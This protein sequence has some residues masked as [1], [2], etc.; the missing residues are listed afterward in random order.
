MRPRNIHNAPIPPQNIISAPRQPRNI[1]NA[2]IPPQNIISAP[3]PPQNIISAPRQPR[4]IHNAPIPPQLLDN[5]LY[6]DE[7]NVLHSALTPNCKFSIIDYV[8]RHPISENNKTYIYKNLAHGGFN[9]AISLKEIRIIENENENKYIENSHVI[10]RAMTD[11]TNVFGEYANSDNYYDRLFNLINQPDS[12]FLVPIEHILK[13]KKPVNARDDINYD[14]VKSLETEW[15]NDLNSTPANYILE[16]NHQRI[17]YTYINNTIKIYYTGRTN[18]TSF[19]QDFIKCCYWVMPY[20]YPFQDDGPITLEKVIQ[21]KNCLIKINRALFNSDFSGHDHKYE[22]FMYTD[23]ECTNLVCTDIDVHLKMNT[24]FE[25]NNTIMDQL[26]SDTAIKLLNNVNI[27]R[28]AAI[29][30]LFTNNHYNDIES[31]GMSHKS[32]T[33]VKLER[34]NQIVATSDDDNKVFYYSDIINTIS[35]LISKLIIISSYSSMLS[36]ENMEDNFG[37]IKININV[38]NDISYYIDNNCINAN[39]IEGFLNNGHMF[40]NIVDNNNTLERLISILSYGISINYNLD[41]II[42]NKILYIKYV[43]M[44]ISNV[45][46]LSS[47]LQFT[48]TENNKTK[49]IT[50]RITILDI[51]N[52]SDT[53]VIVSNDFRTV[54]DQNTINSNFQENHCEN[55]MIFM[56]FLLYKCA[57]NNRQPPPTKEIS[58]VTFILSILTTASTMNNSRDFYNYINDLYVGNVYNINDV[59]NE[60]ERKV[61]IFKYKLIYT[62]LI[63]LLDFKVS[64]DLYK[65]ILNAMNMF[66]MIHTD[67]IFQN[68]NNNMPFRSS[69]Y[70]NKNFGKSLFSMFYNNNF[71]TPENDTELLKF[72]SVFSYSMFL[73][74]ST[75]INI[76]NY[77]INS[78]VQTKLFEENSILKIDQFYLIIFI[79]FDAGMRLHYRARNNTYSFKKFY[80]RLTQLNNLIESGNEIR[81]DMLFLKNY[82]EDVIQNNINVILGYIGEN[83][84]YIETY[85]TNHRSKIGTTSFGY[86]SREHDFNIET[87]FGYDNINKYYNADYNILD[88]NAIP[89]FSETDI[90]E[91]KIKSVFHISPANCSLSIN[92]NVGPMFFDI[93]GNYNNDLEI[94]PRELS[95]VFVKELIYYLFNNINSFINYSNIREIISLDNGYIVDLIHLIHDVINENIDNDMTPDMIIHEVFNVLNSRDNKHHDILMSKEKALNEF[96]NN[97]NILNELVLAVMQ[98]KRKMVN[99]QQEL[100]DNTIV[101]ANLSSKNTITMHVYIPVKCNYADLRTWAVKMKRIFERMHNNLYIAQDIKFNK[102]E[103]VFEYIDP[104]VYVDSTHVLRVP[105]SAKGFIYEDDKHTFYDKYY[106]HFYMIDLVKNRRYTNLTINKKFK[107]RFNNVCNIINNKILKPY[108]KN[109]HHINSFITIPNLYDYHRLIIKENDTNRYGENFENTIKRMFKYTLL[110]PNIFNNELNLNWS[111]PLNTLPFNK[112]MMMHHYFFKAD[113]CIR[114]ENGLSRMRIISFRQ[115]LKDRCLKF[116]ERNGSRSFAITNNQPLSLNDFII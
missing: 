5:Y 10:I 74:D 67:Q 1:H 30:C 31:P 83:R 48:K 108:L 89:T 61:K 44:I 26:N 40:N 65:N 63:S 84:R 16:K 111:S 28:M 38:M 11:Y 41:E 23:E 116:D 46:D 77:L 3:I 66:T 109:V 62:I 64:S 55:M 53:R 50:E 103:H 82:L 106:S 70:S 12:G 100:Y 110:S 42:K 92:N 113:N 52:L 87:F 33:D 19:T 45:N 91:G 68:F 115:M 88:N 60:N 78:F 49:N 93:E 101:T 105:Y 94:D 35:L 4:N 39:F 14:L 56:N 57:D 13:F 20:C 37:N 58:I 29:K 90:H 2:P 81:D 59:T 107:K 75:N 25:I 18:I 102:Y 32:N 112:F 99:F 73:S 6:Y 17:K 22:N 72:M 114:G 9:T 43:L 27:L 15:V 54:F 104:N 97:R 86:A 47:E 69:E 24:F 98:A 21:L 34:L 7:Q 36:N 8:K 71:L 80:R 95:A 76:N 96:L 51:L 79:L 85:N